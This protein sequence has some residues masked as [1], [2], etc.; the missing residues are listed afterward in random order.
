MV[1]IEN[2]LIAVVAGV[3]PYAGLDFQR[4]ILDN[5]IAL[6]DQDH[7]NLIAIS[8]PSLVPDRTAWLMDPLEHA[9][10]GEG[11]F[12][13]AK[14][15]WTLG[16]KALVIACNTAHANK[17]FSPLAVRVQQELPGIQLVHMIKACANYIVEHTPYR[18]IGL[19]ATKGTHN[20]RVYHEYINQTVGLE[21][22]EPEQRGIEKIHNAIYNPEFGIK[23]TGT[24]VSNR[25]E[26]IVAAEIWRLE[27]MGVDAVILG[28][29]ELPLATG[30]KEYEL[31]LIDPGVFAARELLKA[32]VPDRL[33][34]LKEVI[35]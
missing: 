30:H 1:Q 9:D 28:C 17:I 15:A 21:L 7:A 16:A 23:V 6:R 26:S 29:T 14:M 11:L 24:P 20:A 4:K 25:A 34:P 31:P 3:G 35:Y 22:V 2:P 12:T 32:A 27:D 10:P 18:R 8:C 13:C 19:L 33:R 5:T